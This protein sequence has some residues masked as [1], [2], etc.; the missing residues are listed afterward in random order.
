VL[1]RSPFSQFDT[2]EWTRRIELDLDRVV[3]L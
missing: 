3:D 1:A 2:V